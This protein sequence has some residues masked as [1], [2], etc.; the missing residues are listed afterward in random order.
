[1]TPTERTNLIVTI[2]DRVTQLLAPYGIAVAHT[3]GAGNNMAE[4]T[5]RIPEG[6]PADKSKPGKVSELIMHLDFYLLQQYHTSAE[7]LNKLPRDWAAV[8]ADY[9]PELFES[10]PLPTAA[11]IDWRPTEMLPEDF[12]AM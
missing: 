2:N 11:E 1:M 9:A 5:F 6:A 12:G 4:F 7:C 8:I 10:A 3:A